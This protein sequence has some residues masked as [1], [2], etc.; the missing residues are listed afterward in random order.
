LITAGFSPRFVPAPK[1]MTEAVP[2]EIEGGY[3]GTWK[4]L[5]ID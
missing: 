1:R 2:S 3:E 4:S 5:D